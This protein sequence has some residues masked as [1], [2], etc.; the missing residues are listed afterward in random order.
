[1]TPLCAVEKGVARRLSSCGCIDD[2]G[3]ATVE[4]ALRE[5]SWGAVWRAGTDVQF[6]PMFVGVGE[7]LTC[8]EKIFGFWAIVLAGPTKA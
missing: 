5:T 3:V 8:R 4:T 2:R 1:M 7:L 6:G